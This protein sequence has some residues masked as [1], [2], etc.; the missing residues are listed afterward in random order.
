MK[1]TRGQ[2]INGGLIA[3]AAGALSLGALGARWQARR[4]P[5]YPGRMVGASRDLGHLL[6]QAEL[7]HASNEL[8]TRVV[9]VGGGVA[10]LGAARRLFK[11][12]V[13]DILLL[14]LEEG[15]GGNSRGGANEV[16]AYPL[17]AHYVPILTQE[18]RAVRRLF[19]ELGVIVGA[20]ARGQ[21]IYDEYMLGF[22]PKE[23]LLRFGRWQEGMVPAIGATP[24]D[25]AQ[26]RRFFALMNEL[27]ERRGSDGRRLFAIPIDESSV[28]PVWRELDLMTMASWMDSQGFT[29]QLLRWYVNYACRDDYGTTYN[30]TSAWAG[31]H[32][33]ASRNGR[34]AN[35]ES[36]DVV[37][38]PQGNGWLVERMAAPLGSCIRTRWLTTQVVTSD[39]E[40]NLYVWDANERVM[41]LIRAEAAVLA[42]PRFVTSRLLPETAKDAG[43]FSY[44]PWVVANITVDRMPE[45]NGAALS[46]DNVAFDGRTLGYVVATNQQLDAK[47]LSTVLTAYWPL[48]HATPADARQEALGRNL[49]EWQ[50]LFADDLIS[51]HPELSGHIRSID[52][53]IWGHA[54]IRPVPGFIWGDARKRAQQPLGRVAF[55]H[56]DLSGISIFEEA[57]T[58]GVHAAEHILTL[59]E[60]DHESEL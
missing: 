18:A 45:G 28:D 12:G 3:S 36:D 55:A 51:I 29:S 48:S 49:D 16:S 17:G 32:Y 50:H 27:K 10:G 22:E 38:W 53:C 6:R 46:W 43:A 60:V 37:T 19:E 25:E 57:Y 4:P 35:A 56:S 42:T 13:N 11:A 41:R 23:R 9:V 26:Y 24:E 34:S 47:P 7:P 52:V 44:A 21:P 1:L 8:Y 31:V 20:D 40:V 59:L 39:T 14:D 58:R 54:M 33:F 5:V 30:E 2:F 15:L